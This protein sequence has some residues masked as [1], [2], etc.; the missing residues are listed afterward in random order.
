MGTYEDPKKTLGSGE[1][2]SYLITLVSCFL[3]Q[4]ARRTGGI[5]YAP[6]QILVEAV[7]EGWGLE[8]GKY[9]DE[10]AQWG[11]RREGEGSKQM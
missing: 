6:S 10:H 7:R 8:N 5:F 11:G 1:W 3:Y 4:Q 9:I 2:V